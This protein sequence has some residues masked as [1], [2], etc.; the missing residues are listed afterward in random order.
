MSKWVAG[1]AKS[2]WQEGPAGKVGAVLLVVLASLAIG[3]L[4]YGVSH[5]AQ[6]ARESGLSCGLRREAVPARAAGLVQQLAKATTE[7]TWHGN[8]AWLA[9]E[10]TV[11][12]VE[13]LMPTMILCLLAGFGRLNAAVEEAAASLGGTHLQV[14]L[15]VVLPA[16]RPALLAAYALAFARALGEYGS[17]IFIAGNMPMVS[18]ITP[19]II[20]TK[21]EQY[22]YTGATAVAVV[23]L[24]VSFALLL[25]IN[26]FQ[27]L[28][29]KRNGT[30]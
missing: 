21:L 9:G 28:T 15:R 1:V 8:T 24:I 10:V 12:L 13:I 20:V 19:L 3:L 25:L 2:L 16:L 4:R 23:M 22:D 27:W 30:T 11:A 17:V 7:T 29:R 18:E 14:L 26:Y 6:L 5:S